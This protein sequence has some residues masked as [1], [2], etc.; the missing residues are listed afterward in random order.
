MLRK[1]ECILKNST[2]IS[3][4]QKVLANVT[5]FYGLDL[6]KE[7]LQSQLTILHSGSGTSFNGIKSAILY[8]TD[9]LQR[10]EN[11]IPK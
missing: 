4:K 10:R 11:S 5:D 3:K 1:L 6:N 2:T 8:L 9:C 7:H